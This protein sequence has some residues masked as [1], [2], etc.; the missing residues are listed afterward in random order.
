MARFGIGES[1]QI[2]CDVR[3]GAMPTEYLVTFD[4]ADGRLSGFV[5]R[6][7]LMRVSGTSGFIPAKIIATKGDIL[8]VQ[9]NGSFFTTTGLVN[10]KRDWAD[11]HVQPFSAVA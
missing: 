8:T 6:E 4:T 10:F 3:P 5:R 11:S 7:Q 1:V 9:V 2:P